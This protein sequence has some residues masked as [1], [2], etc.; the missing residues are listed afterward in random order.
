MML[1]L[2]VPATLGLLVLATPIVRLIFERGPIHAR[3]HRRDGRRARRA[4]RR[5]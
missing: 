3:R 5:G 2:N 4:T 1:M